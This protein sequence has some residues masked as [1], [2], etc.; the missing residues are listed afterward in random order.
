MAKGGQFERDVCRQLS[1]WWT[2]GKRDD[3]FWR[4]AGSGARATV[5][6]KAGRK[7]FG[8]YGDITATDPIGQPLM[9][10]LTLELKRGYSKTSFADLL[11]VSQ[12]AKQQMFAKWVQQA[13]D[14][15]E[16]SGSQA[17]CLITKRDQRE[18]LIFMPYSLVLRFRKLE[19]RA[20]H[21]RLFQPW[22]ANH[23]RL[24]VPI[25]IMR[26]LPTGGSPVQEEQITQIYGMRLEEFL[27]EVQPADVKALLQGK[28]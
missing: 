4:T 5:R 8:S 9:K 12:R 17:W 25:H 28:A 19:P 21:F 2:T 3:V 13:C 16:A 24:F 1:L 20:T 11:D 10:L 7:T 18:C 27:R 15:A 6:K 22:P 14:A 26:T 23:L